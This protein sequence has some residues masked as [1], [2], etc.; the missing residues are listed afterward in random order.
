MTRSKPL[1]AKRIREIKEFKNIDFSD[2]QEITDEQATQ[3]RPRYPEHFRPI[4]KAVQIRIDSDVLAW[5]KNSGKGYQTKINEIL[6]DVM[7]ESV[8]K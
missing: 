5:F 4:K 2:C 3:L 1:T 6:R 7:L 8:E